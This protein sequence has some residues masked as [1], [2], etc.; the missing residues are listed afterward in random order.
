M[1][2]KDG[3]TRC[4]WANPNN[5]IYLRYHDEEWG[6]PVHDD[7]KLF[8][9]L[10]LE[11]FQAGLSWEC[12]LNKQEAFREA[13]DG[14]DLEKVRVRPEEIIFDELSIVED[15]RSIPPFCPSF[16]AGTKPR[17]S[18]TKRTR[19]RRRSMRRAFPALDE[20]RTNSK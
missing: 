19:H 9:M 2:W 4:G 12:V 17:S 20:N 7:H 14:F 1:E 16:P 10:I 3:K 18:H 5:D 15:R 11:C 8:E 13:F 6:V